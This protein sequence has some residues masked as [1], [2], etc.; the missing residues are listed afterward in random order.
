MCK[1][2]PQIT[3]ECVRPLTPLSGK[4]VFPLYRGRDKGSAMSINLVTVT[5]AGSCKAGADPQVT[6]SRSH[7][8]ITTTLKSVRPATRGRHHDP[9]LP[10]SPPQKF[11]ALRPLLLYSSPHSKEEAQLLSAGAH[12]SS[13]EDVWHRRRSFTPLTSQV[14]LRLPPCDTDVFSTSYRA[15]QIHL[16]PSGTFSRKYPPLSHPHTLPL[17]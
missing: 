9:Y 13:S 17:D 4:L 7:I 6:E 2:F 5:Q 16:R 8:L 12:D 3:L 1:R 14:A 11:P 10:F 15:A